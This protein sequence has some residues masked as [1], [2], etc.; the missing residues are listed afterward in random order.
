MIPDKANKKQKALYFPSELAFHEV[1]TRCSKEFRRGLRWMAP[2]NI[3]KTELM[4]PSFQASKE[5]IFFCT[6][7]QKGDMANPVAKEFHG[8]IPI[9][10]VFFC[11]GMLQ[12]LPWISYGKV[13]DWIPQKWSF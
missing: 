4:K 9:C 7:T 13:L 1:A 3:T 12:H 8:K 6:P 10:T 2:L 11:L 5:V